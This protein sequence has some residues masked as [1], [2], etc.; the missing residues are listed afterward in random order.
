MDMTRRHSTL[1]TT[2][3]AL[4]VV[5]EQEAGPQDAVVGLYFPGH[6]HPPAPDSLGE[7]VDWGSDGLFRQLHAEL[8]EYLTG[9]RTH[10]E[11]PVRTHGGD[12]DERVWDLLVQIP[13]GHTTTYGQLAEQFGNRG[14]AQRV[15]RAVG[16]N[17]VSILIPCHR[18]VGAGG[19]LTGYAGGLERKRRLLEIES[20]AAP[21]A[22]RLF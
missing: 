5:A 9:G 22:G 2:L 18:V 17:P 11:V 14:L 13:Y 15:G 16:H 1:P 20:P 8:A 12:F 6:W 7:S 3:G 21:D 10:F 4:L 19:S